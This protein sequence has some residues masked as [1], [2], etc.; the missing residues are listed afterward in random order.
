MFS[1][2][3][4]QSNTPPSTPPPSTGSNQVDQGSTPY[5]RCELRVAGQEKTRV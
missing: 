1:F 5:A 2:P 3:I 4:P